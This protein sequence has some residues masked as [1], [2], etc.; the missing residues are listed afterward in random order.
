MGSHLFVLAS[1]LLA[2]HLPGPKRPQ[3]CSLGLRVRLQWFNKVKSCFCIT[4]I[5]NDYEQCIA[6]I[7]YFL[8][9]APCNYERTMMLSYG[10]NLVYNGFYIGNKSC[11][12][13]THILR[14]SWFT[15][16]S[17]KWT[18]T[19]RISNPGDTHIRTNYLLSS[20]FRC[21]WFNFMDFHAHTSK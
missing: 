9:L 12:P 5:S 7:R 15:S 10:E 19:C 20:V 18:D 8:R 2:I 1:R 3:E 4:E 13:N 11:L 21:A 14:L 17:S 6:Y 16:R